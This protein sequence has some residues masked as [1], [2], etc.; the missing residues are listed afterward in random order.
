MRILF[1]APRLCVPADTGAKIRTLNILKQIAKRCEVDYVSFYFDKSDLNHKKELER[2]GIHVFLVEHEKTKLMDVAQGVLF[3]PRPFSVS[4]YDDDSM[5]Q[6]ILSLLTEKKY[7]LVHVDHVHMT[8][9]RDCF[10]H[11][12]CLVDE[13]NIE[14]K[15]LERCAD[16][17][18]SL[19]K[20]FLYTSQSA[21]MKSFES[22]SVSRFSACTVVSDDDRKILSDLTR[23]NF[24]IHVVPNGVDTS[25]FHQADYTQKN[26]AVPEE[27]AV[28]FT[29]SMDWL[30]NEDAVIY[31]AKEI[32]PLV[33][34]KKPDAKFYIVGKSPSEEIKSLAGRNKNIV[35]TGRVDDVRSY[36]IKS[37]VFVVPLR[38]GGGTRLK[39]LEAMAMEK[40]IVSTTIG[41]EGIAYRHGEDILIADAPQ[42]FANTVLSLM[43]NDNRR[44]SM[45]TKARELVCRSYDWEFVGRKLVSIYEEL[46]AKR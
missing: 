35:I 38:I 18:K 26:G 2:Y 30:P 42:E 17:E 14:F 20:K 7:D 25:F 9:Y 44:K 3:D 34:E 13:H 45:G 21:K 46:H 5:R 22:Y 16:V 1:I 32:F 4:K 8:H 12:H 11:V 36:I 15:I 23:R 39:I 29:G 43:E 33:L 28:V 31:F 19:V 27:D 41:A 37:K 6:M 10:S 24:P 40:A